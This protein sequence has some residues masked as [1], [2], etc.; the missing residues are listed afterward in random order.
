LIMSALP[1]AK[2][3]AQSTVCRNH[4]H[5]I[6]LA[7]QMYASEHTIYPSA[8]GGPPLNTWADQLASYYPLNW[9][10]LAW[11]CPTYIAEG[12][13][14]I[15]QRP[16]PGGGR[17]HVTSSY[18]YNAFGMIGFGT[19]GAALTQKG[20]WLGLGALRWTVRE[21][22]IAAPSEMYA[23]ADTRPLR[24]EGRSGCEGSVKMNSWQLF[25]SALN[26]KN[27]EVD[28]P[29]GGSYNLLFVDGHVNSVKR[30]DY[31]YPPRAAQNW[32]RD[33]QPHPE[34]W[35]APSEWVIPN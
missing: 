8:M 34:L 24:Y 29:H 12:G 17:F 7:M 32:N 21:I 4:L 25:P 35:S 2:G 16:P 14:V 10:N 30:T 28:A 31:L 20:S 3:Q 19:N 33:H 1:N 23:V 11:H 26:A 9:T 6:G 5:Q 15:W 18:A 13:K 27:A 22:G